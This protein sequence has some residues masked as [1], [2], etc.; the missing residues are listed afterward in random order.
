MGNLTAKA[1]KHAKPGRYSDGKGLLLMVRPSGSKRWILR[2]QVNGKR[3]DIGLGSASDVSLSSARDAADDMRKAF[4]RGE[5]PLRARNE[6]GEETPTF[7][8]AA[9]LVHRENEKGWKNAKHR[10]QWL[11]SLETYAFPKL[12]NLAINEISGPDVR[13]V[14]AE[15]WL[16]LPETARRVLQRICKV[17]D[18]GHA[19]GWREAEAPLRAIRAGLPKQPTKP[20]EETHFE[21]MPWADVPAFF[22][23]MDELGATETTRLCLEY[24]ILTACRSG[25]TRGAK[26]S[27]VDLDQRVWTIPAARMKGKRLHRVP[28]C[29]RAVEILTR[30]QELRHS[31]KPTALVFEGRKIGRP[32]SDMTLTQILRRAGLSCTPHGFRS[33]FRDWTEENTGY[34]TAL[35]EKALAHALKSKVEASY[36][37]GDLLEKRRELMAAWES[38]CLSERN[39]A[40]NVTRLRRKKARRGG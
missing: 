37:R 13:D 26:W 21:A 11:S 29:E 14:T 9:E 22:A 15:I 39:K 18:Y 17:L 33:S 30:M 5:N 3:R 2:V 25:E 24:T 12:G 28:L 31:A 23:R 19:K 38:Y 10:A 7:R 6:E 4:K 35:A 40:S 34:P 16:V 20:P 32:M 36:Q 1:V 8:E 27:E